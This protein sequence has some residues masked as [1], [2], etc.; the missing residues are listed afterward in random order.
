MIVVYVSV[1]TKE[2]TVSEF[3]RS[4]REIQGEVR[5]MAGCVKN[6]WYRV[7]DAPQ[8]YVIYGEFDTK[9]NFEKY[10]S[11]ATVKRIGAELIPLLEAPPEFKHY[12]ATILETN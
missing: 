5:Q 10:L 8:R 4:L 11:S 2:N 6:E 1:K 9:E 7:P 3:E 12:E